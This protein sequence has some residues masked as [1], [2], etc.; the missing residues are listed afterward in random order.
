MG[1]SFGHIDGRRRSYLAAVNLSN[2]KL[3]P[4]HPRANDG[5]S[6]LAVTADTVY[7]GGE[8][9]SISGI[10]RKYLAAIDGRNGDLATWNPAPDDD[11][12]R[13]RLRLSAAL[14][15]H[16]AAHTRIRRDV[17]RRAADC[18]PGRA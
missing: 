4:W 5:V 18:P 7:A 10:R 1:G 6:A 13:Y 2:G 9:T 3:L 14:S 12:T 15:T 17:D 16:F 8:F 11:D